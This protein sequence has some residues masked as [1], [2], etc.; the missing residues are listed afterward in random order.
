MKIR[1]ICPLLLLTLAASAGASDQPVEPQPAF[2]SVPLASPT[3]PYP[4]MD[5]R[6]CI[7]GKAVFEFSVLESGEV[8]EVR[9]VSAP[10]ACL[11]RPAAG[12]GS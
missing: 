3:P 6:Q 8:G 9:I 5:L 12:I 7:G 4:Q 2:N 1:R 11:I 10:R